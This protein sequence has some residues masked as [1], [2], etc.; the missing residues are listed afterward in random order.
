MM[1]N[2]DEMMKHKK[3]V[4]MDLMGKMKELQAGSLQ[5][6]SDPSD[7]EAVSD[8][9]GGNA[10][11]PAN[12]ESNEDKS[13]LSHED[14]EDAEHDDMNA[15]PESHESSHESSQHDSEGGSEDF[16][17]EESPED[18]AEESS[19]IHPALAKLLAE[20]MKRK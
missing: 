3:N 14:R 11:E 8:E 17:N 9:H 18:Q 19:N 1:K 2:E 10:A 5:K 16:G 12:E 6:H 20:H 4:L 7:D 15:S 13:E